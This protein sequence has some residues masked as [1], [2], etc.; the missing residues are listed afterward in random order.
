MKKRLVCGL[1]ATSMVCSMF[2]GCA[3]QEQ[4]D[5]K[6]ANGERV[7][8]TVGIPQNSNITSYEDNAFTKYL[9]ESLNMDLEFVFFSSSTSENTQQ[10]SLMVSGN[11][12]LPDVLWGFYE[13]NQSMTNDFGEDGYF[14]DL[15]EPLEKY[16]VHYWE[17]LEKLDE[18]MQEYVK[19]KGV[20][21]VDGGFYSMPYVQLR[22]QDD[23]GSMTYI[24]KTWLDNLG[25]QM[26]TTVDE[27]YTV[28]DAFATRDPNGNGEAD[29]IPMVSAARGMYDITSYL[30]N[31]YE[32]FDN[33]NPYYVDGD[34]VIE[35]AATEEYRQALITANKF[36][37][38]GLLSDLSFSITAT[39]EFLSLIT[40]ADN[41]ARVGIW[42]GHPSI[43][44]DSSSTILDQ[45]TALPALKDETGKG[46]Y[47][48]VRE[49]SV[50]YSSGMI[51]KDCENVE[52]AM[53]FLDFFY[54]DETVSRM[55]HGE[56]GVDW[57]DQEGTNDYGD[58][59]HIQ[60]VNGNAFF[61]GNSTWGRNSSTILTSYNY[62]AN[63]IEG[64]GRAAEVSRLSGET[65]NLVENAEIPEKNI[66]YLLYTEE[67]DNLKS[68]K[69]EL[70]LSAVLEQRALFITGEQ[71][72]ASDS[73]WQ[74]YLNTLKKQGGA[75]ILKIKQD[76]YDRKQASK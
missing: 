40:P 19:E 30:I 70:Y 28:L 29:E 4:E 8:L 73:A 54:Q 5:G 72:P 20:D 58:P 56:K 42:A 9:E 2:G 38:A 39:S 34:T 48:L 12:E 74:E 59:G 65:W 17:Q 49:Q 68:E 45:Y 24:N 16:A 43:M 14:I 64:S 37:K 71:N 63:A 46:G 23:I 76:A 13:M 6:K 69:Q 66:N 3:G 51:T 41:V 55:R 47:Q 15:T 60:I 57:I 21:S 11:Q 35:A 53:K 27:L 52:A 1:L 10:L 22:A 67:E 33:M 36:C 61:K 7:T 50:Y 44:T 75:E 62:L 25:L 32:Y 18:D 31:A 26:P